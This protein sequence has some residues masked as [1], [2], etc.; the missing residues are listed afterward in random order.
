MSHSLYSQLK[1][2]KQRKRKSVRPQ[3]VQRAMTTLT[4][5]KMNAFVILKNVTNLLKDWFKKIKRSK[6]ILSRSQTKRLM[7]RQQKEL[8]WYAL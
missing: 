6:E 3:P 5:S 8:Q 7:R 4:N 1:L 2:K